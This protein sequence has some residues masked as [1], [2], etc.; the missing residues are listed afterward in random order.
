MNLSLGG[1]SITG[2]PSAVP[3]GAGYWF[4]SLS[5]WWDAAESTGQTTQFLLADGGWVDRGFRAFRQ[6]ELTGHV[7]AESRPELRDAIE[8]LMASI[9]VD[10]LVPFVVYEDGLARHCM[11]R[12]S[13]GPKVTWDNGTLPIAS[14][15]ISLVAPDPR[16]LAGSGGED[17]WRTFGPVPLP[18]TTGGLTFPFSLPAP[19]A[20]VTSSGQVSLQLGGTAQGNTVIE[21]AGPVL[22]PGV[23][24]V[25]TGKPLW[26]DIE[27]TAGQVLSVDL[28][29]RS[30]LLNGVSRRGTRRGQW[31]TPINDG[32]WEF[33]ASNYD[34]A[35]RMSVRTQEAWI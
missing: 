16:K 8:R 12:M 26:F 11:V 4:T 22:N 27:L 18:Q 2:T 34:P 1:V 21:F 5:G 28:R 6:I 20:A 31:V 7:E 19:I 25:G 32:A 35:A 13:G 33:T 23:R 10:S 15:N 17:G 30:V 24:E 9:P 29:T 14:W 3:Y